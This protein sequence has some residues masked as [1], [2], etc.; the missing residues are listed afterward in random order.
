MQLPP[1]LSVAGRLVL[2]ASLLWLL[3]VPRPAELLAVAQVLIVMSLRVMSHESNNLSLSTVVHVGLAVTLLLL[4]PEYPTGCAFASVLLYASNY[5][6]L[7]RGPRPTTTDL[8]GQVVVVTGSSAGIGYETARELLRL[9]ATVIFACRSEPRAQ[10]AMRAAAAAVGGASAA[11]RVKFLKLDLSD[12]ESVRRC[13][14]DFMSE[15]GGKCDALVCNAGGMYATREATAQGWELNM[16]ANHLGHHLLIQLMVPALRRPERPGGRAGCVVS[17]TS[18]THKAPLCTTKGAGGAKLAAALRRDVMSEG[19]YSLFG[20]YSKSKLA[21]VLCTRALQ[22]R[23]PSRGG[24]GGGD[25]GG[26]GGGGGGVCF[27]CC[28][29][30]NSLTD[31]TRHFPYAIRLAYKVLGFFFETVQVAPPDAAN[32]SVHAVCRAAADGLHGAYLERCRP[33]RP[34]AAALDD[35]LVAEIAALSDE[36]VAPWLPKAAF[37][38]RKSALK[39][40]GTIDAGIDAGIDAFPSLFKEGGKQGSAS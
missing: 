27:V 34:S 10:A 36:L 25:G 3:G 38:P 5:L 24:G 31:I 33:V 18:S 35:E 20:A 17:V 40:L 15:H 2:I 9:G 16:G 19:D 30:G 8:T 21:Q 23:E 11:T 14:A 1:V 12:A 4:S 37:S 39:A 6:V 7:I 22:R 13:A 28:H 32:S 29:P 26:G